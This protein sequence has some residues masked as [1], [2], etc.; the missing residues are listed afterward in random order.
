VSASFACG[1]IVGPLLGTALYEIDPH[2]TFGVNAVLTLV[3]L[4]LASW[5][6]RDRKAPG[7]TSRLNKESVEA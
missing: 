4:G 2:I 3:A 5:A 1:F 6:T 7:P